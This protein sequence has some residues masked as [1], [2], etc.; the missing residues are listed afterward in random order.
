MCEQML[1]PETFEKFVEQYKIVDT[2]A[3]YTNGSELIPVFRVKQWLEHT[4]PTNVRQGAWIRTHGTYG[5]VICS[6]CREVASLEG[7]DEE[8]DE[9]DYI[10]SS[11]CPHCGAMMIMEKLN[12]KTR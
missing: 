10:R 6:E 5:E 2:Q 3:V 1:F 11:F 9:W 7:T 4:K 8:E 12:D